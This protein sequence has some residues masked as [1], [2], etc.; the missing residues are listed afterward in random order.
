[1]ITTIKELLNE[2]FNLR[3]FICHTSLDYL[4]DSN[5]TKEELIDS[6]MA[7]IKMWKMHMIQ[8]IIERSGTEKDAEENKKMPISRSNRRT[9]QK[10]FSVS[11]MEKNN[12]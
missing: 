7:G 9:M 4:N 5:A 1:M 8:L 12:E 2:E 3:H 6:V 10:R 11:G